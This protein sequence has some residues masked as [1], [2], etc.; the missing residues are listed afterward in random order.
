MEI[1]M[2][3]PYLDAMRDKVAAMMY[4]AA[5]EQMNF[6]NDILA[7]YY[8]SYNPYLDKLAISDS[9]LRT[10]ATNAFALGKKTP[11]QMH[12]QLNRMGSSRLH[13]GLKALRSGN[14]SMLN[15]HWL[16]PNRPNPHAI[17]ENLNAFA[18][19][20][21]PKSADPRLAMAEAMGTVR[22]IPLF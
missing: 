22:K 7:S 14:T 10:A 6:E 20:L 5:V 9:L 8:G 12:A 15:Y 19:F 13:A 3:Y 4:D 11:Q 2:N 17:G 1:T 18:R 16:D 21:Y